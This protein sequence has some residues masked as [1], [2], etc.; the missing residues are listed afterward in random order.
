MLLQ[1]ATR[2]ARS[3]GHILTG[4]L[5][6]TYSRLYLV[7]DDANWS[8]RQDMREVAA[9]AAKLGIRQRVATGIGRV[10]NQA[11]FHSS[12]YVLLRNDL[13]R[14]DPHRIGLA[15]FHGLP[16]TP[17]NDTLN[18][19]YRQL[20]RYHRVIDRIQVSHTQMRDAILESGISPGKVHLIRIAVNTDY[21]PF[22]TPALKQ[23]ARRTLGLPQ[24]AVI[25]GSFQKD[26]C[27]W[28][29]GFDPKFIKGPDVLCD[30]LAILK[31]RVP[32]LHVLLT[33]PARGY[34]KKRLEQ[35]GLPYTHR[36]VDHYAD[37]GQY[38]QALD[39]YI[40]ASR[41]EGGPKAIFEA[42]SSGVPIISTCV[43]QAMDVMEHGVNGWVVAS[44]DTEA[45]AH[46]T[47][48]ALSAR[49][50]AVLKA[51]RATAESNTYRS[52][53]PLWKNFFDGF[54]SSDG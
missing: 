30:A 39:A 42:M 52:Q 22:Q 44:E 38:F 45:L 28:G 50:D 25:V 49:H 15:Y 13:A 53:I 36:Y 20:C 26:G 4:R 35:I 16:N 34:V 23:A 24:S 1:T 31:Q 41:Q 2:R 51:G 43:G 10:P 47:Q 27:G 21:F 46:W 9:I 7:A 11:T 48:V 17:G 32:G 3:V 19:C 37:I 29:E 33:G 5:A 40:V 8:L 54:V 18:Q 6:P 14:F 12:P